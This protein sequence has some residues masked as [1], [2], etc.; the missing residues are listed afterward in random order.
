MFNF[1]K[2]FLPKQVVHVIER[3]PIRARY[4]AAQTGHENENHWAAA[5]SLGPISSNDSYTRNK[6]AIRARH[7]RDNN[8][9]L[10]GG[11]RLHGLSF[12]GT[13]PRLQLPMDEGL[14]DS[15]RQIET[16]FSK[17]AK[18]VKLADKLRLM[19]EA[20]PID[21]ESFAQFFENDAIEGPIKLD[22]QVIE[23]EQ[24]AT[25]D[26]SLDTRVDGMEIDALGN[27]TVYHL[28][29]E[30][31][32][33]SRGWKQSYTPIPA[34][35]MLHWHR[36]VRPGQYRS[37]SELASSLDTCGQTR[38]Y[39][40]ATLGK[41]EAN[42]NIAGV[43]ESENV[44]VGD[45]TAPTFETMEEIDVPRMG[46]MTMPAGMKAKPFGT[47]ENTTGYR[48]YMMTNHG[49]TCRPILL[50]LN[51]YTGDSSGFN[52]ASGRM[53]HLPYQ[54]SVWAE[55]ERFEIEIL[56]KILRNFY[57]AANSAGLV[58]KNLPA[59]SE[60]SIAWQWDGFPS[61][62]QTKDETARE[63]RLK[64]GISTL[65]E[66]CAAEGKDWRE[67]AR[68]Q[69]AERAYYVKLGLDDPYAVLRGTVK[70]PMPETPADE[71]ASED[72]TKLE[73]ASYGRYLAHV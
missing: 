65:S 1:L 15:T 61:I 40:K 26:F 46:L 31:P 11:I 73:Q 41:Q 20:A 12:I 5:D 69:A 24:I 60:W 13:G 19:V 72:D 30:H 71:P 29:D 62:D 57:A 50:P 16:L 18:S 59:F 51:S 47:A 27:V 33:D 21:G 23:Q 66:E 52:F 38:R 45:E 55:R 58:P 22:L 4:D 17:W 39:A 37:V 67:V 49:A 14:Y 8:P 9:H 6:L 64:N 3:R 10:Y 70:P 32:G 48:E 53:D 36:R 42:A 54:A 25:P 68:Q 44:M 34:R 56:S 2:R 28:L 43:I 63:M 7:E 35:N